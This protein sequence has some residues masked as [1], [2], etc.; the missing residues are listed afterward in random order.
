MYV[1]YNAKEIGKQCKLENKMK[2]KGGKGAGSRR[3]ESR[4]EK[5]IKSKERGQN[6]AA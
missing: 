5:V 1:E 3:K 2:I 4:R 6:V